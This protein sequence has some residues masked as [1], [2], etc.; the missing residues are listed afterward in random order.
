LLELVERGRFPALA[1]RLDLTRPAICLQ[2]RECDLAI[3]L[4]KKRTMQSILGGAAESSSTAI[5]RIAVPS[6]PIPV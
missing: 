6:A 1:H 2:I 4:P 5:P 3:T